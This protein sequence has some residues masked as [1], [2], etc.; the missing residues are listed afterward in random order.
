MNIAE[1]IVPEFDHECTVSRTVLERVPD[2]KADW[3]P[4]A[5]AFSLA[6]LAQLVATMPGWMTTACKE[7]GIDFAP[8]NRPAG[9]GYANHS[10][11]DL[12]AMFEKGVTEGRAALSSVTDEQMTDP[13]TS[14]AG[15]VVVATQPRYDV[16]RMMTLN[17]QV[18]HRAQLGLYLRMLDEKVPEMYGPTADT[19]GPMQQGKS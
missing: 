6:H 16:I 14:R 4:H 8:K 13:W 5:K 1:R 19:K 9:S 11:K 10:T 7:D 12:L 18:H 15:D 3:K 17:H 2:D